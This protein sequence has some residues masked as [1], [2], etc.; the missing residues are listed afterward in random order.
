MLELMHRSGCW[1]IS[2]GIESGDPDMLR[3][4]HKG[5]TLDAVERALEWSHQ[6]GIKNWGYFIIG[7][8][9]ET[10]ASIRRTI[11]FSKSL[12]LDLA[13]FHIAAPH[14]GRFLL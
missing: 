13:L 8:P 5:I 1:M 3:R 10:V 9:G 4:M 14:P 2:W 11:D 7:L 6:A 12:P